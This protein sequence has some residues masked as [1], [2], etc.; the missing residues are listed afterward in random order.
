MSFFVTASVVAL[1]VVAS[2]R[3]Y[4]RVARD[5]VL[6]EQAPYP[7]GR[8]DSV[9]RPELGRVW[10]SRSPIGSRTPIAEQVFPEPGPASYGAAADHV[11]DLILV[12]V[13]TQLIE[14]NPWER[15][16]NRGLQHLEYARNQW[17]KEQGWVGGVRTHVN[18]MHLRDEGDAM[19]GPSTPTP[20]ATIRLNDE[21]P[22]RP[23]K[24]RVMD[25][26]R[27]EPVTRIFKPHSVSPS[28]LITVLPK[29][30][31]DLA[32]AGDE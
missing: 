4:V 2:D 5:A 12:R 22:R 15:I 23:Y 29:E 25:P 16:D 18:P 28:S 1:S 10:M 6:A 13:N 7:A 30:E 31:A 11:N 32:E 20:R 27:G 21:V 19:Y 9:H 17:L 26:N 8:V 14:I 3:S 24:M